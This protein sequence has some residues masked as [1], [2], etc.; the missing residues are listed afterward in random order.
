MSLGGV[1]FQPSGPNACV[2][3]ALFQ[4]LGESTLVMKYCTISV[5]RAQN[6]CIVKLGRLCRDFRRNAQALQKVLEGIDP[7][8]SGSFVS[9]F[10]VLRCRWYRH[11]LTMLHVDAPGNGGWR[12]FYPGIF[13]MASQVQEFYDRRTRGQVDA[14]GQFALHDLA[15]RNARFGTQLQVAGVDATARLRSFNN[16][17]KTLLLESGSAACEK[18]RG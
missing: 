2:A 5:T 3:A 7:H 10:L 16:C 13:D 17:I 11:G 4:T 14:K 15:W 6:L 18:G 1:S 8:S 9:H 12:L